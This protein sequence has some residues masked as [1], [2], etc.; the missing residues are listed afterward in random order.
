[1]RPQPEG[2]GEHRVNGGTSLSPSMASMRP[3]PEGRGE[4]EGV[5]AAIKRLARLQCGHS[6]KAVENPASA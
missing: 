5:R 3:Q 2:R 4:P 6:P 1:M